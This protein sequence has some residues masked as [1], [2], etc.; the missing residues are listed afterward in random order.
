[1][2]RAADGPSFVRSPSSPRQIPMHC[3][4]C[5]TGRLSPLTGVCELCG[6]SSRASVTVE[7]ADELVRF[8]RRELAHEFDLF[9]PVGRSP[10]SAAVLA[11]ERATGRRVVIRLIARGP[12][13]P[14]ADQLFRAALATQTGFDHPNIVPVGRFGV[15]DSL[16]WYTRD[17]LQATS[18]REV[19][20]QGSALDART[21]RRLATQLASALDYLHRRGTI[22]CAL[23]PENVLMDRNG[24]AHLCDPAL[25]FER[26]DERPAWRAPEDWARNERFP[27]ADQYGLAAL[28]FECLTREPPGETPS[29][30]LLAHPEVP[31]HMAAAIVRALGAEAR[32]RFPSLSE[33]VG[34]L[35]SGAPTLRDA[36][37]VKRTSGS[38][39]LIPDWKPAETPARSRTLRIGVIAI[40]VLALGAAAVVALPRLREAAVDRQPM[41]VHAP[42]PP[43]RTS[44]EVPDEPPIAAPTVR[45][46]SPPP[47]ATTRPAPAASDVAAAP[48]SGE[49]AAV[50]PTLPPSVAAPAAAR[51]FVS[52]SP[53]G[54]LWIDDQLVGNTPRANVALTPGE[55]RLRIVREGYEPFEQT[56]R[57]RAGEELRLTDIRLQPRRP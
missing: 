15:T 9:D 37:P 35:E 32:D 50:T 4:S 54:Q 28:L 45:A 46:P 31:A 43:I 53:W 13:G 38:V 48:A 44:P 29:E 41:Q 7:S 22:H 10:Q 16:R 42:P 1:M 2:T 23:R 47:A 39:V 8:A 19:L 20:A 21:C 25:T 36:R 55:H 3:P 49:P 11:T 14:D 24:W 6:F 17:D 5:S 34:A 12:G 40:G 18:L 30:T 33:F 57:V 26:T 56:V 51:L 27:A 52:A